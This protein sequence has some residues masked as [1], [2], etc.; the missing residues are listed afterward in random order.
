MVYPV[1]KSWSSGNLKFFLQFKNSI[2]LITL[3]VGQEPEL[4][5]TTDNY[6]RSPLHYV[7]WNTNPNQLEIAK[8]LLDA[9][10]ILLN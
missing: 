1:Q 10:G 8:K 3:L 2:E 7:V 5:F 6:L 4:V 9:K